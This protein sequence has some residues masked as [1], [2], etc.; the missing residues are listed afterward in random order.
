[1][2]EIRGSGAA[3]SN[4][5]SD[6]DASRLNRAKQ[7]GS[8]AANSMKIADPGKFLWMALWRAKFPDEPVANLIGKSSD[9][10]SSDFFKRLIKDRDRGVIINKESDNLVAAPRAGSNTLPEPVDVVK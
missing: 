10:L 5:S 1:M 3:P 7:A 8:E 4:T 2:V 9:E 6:A